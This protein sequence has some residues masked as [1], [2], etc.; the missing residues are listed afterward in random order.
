MG[1]EKMN[2]SDIILWIV[3]KIPYRRARLAECAREQRNL[4]YNFMDQ[5]IVHKN[6]C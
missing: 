6:N 3:Y 5:K 1:F 2:I 4:A